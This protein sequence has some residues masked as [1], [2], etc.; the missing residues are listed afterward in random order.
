[1]ANKVYIASFNAT[2]NTIT[3]ALNSSWVLQSP[4][5]EIRLKS[6]TL[7]WSIKELL[8]NYNVPWES[9]TDQNLLLR[10]GMFQPDIGYAVENIVG[11]I[12]QRNIYISEPTVMHFNSFFVVNTMNF[13]I[14][15]TNLSVLNIPHQHSITIL[16]ETSEKTIFIQ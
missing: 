14:N 5:R 2:L 8:N 6:V 11:T 1:M 15:V 16:I 10:I 7:T 4:G 9:C 13:E 12:P 3:P